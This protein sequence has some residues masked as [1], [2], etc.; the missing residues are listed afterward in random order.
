VP[1]TRNHTIGEESVTPAA[2]KITEI[3]CGQKEAME[4]NSVPLSVKVVKE[5]VV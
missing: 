4:L 3:M 2:L 1:E 5:S